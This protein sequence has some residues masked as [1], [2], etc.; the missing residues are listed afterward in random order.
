MFRSFHSAALV[1]GDVT[2]A[3]RLAFAP[4]EAR[5]SGDRGETRCAFGAWSSCLRARCL[6]LSTPRFGG[7]RELSASALS[8]VCPVARPVARLRLFGSIVNQ[9]LFHCF[10]VSAVCVTRV[11]ATSPFVV[12]LRPSR[13]GVLAF[14]GF[15]LGTVDS[16][17]CTS[18]GVN[19]L[20][21][22]S[23]DRRGAGDVRRLRSLGPGTRL[24]GLQRLRQ[25][26]VRGER[27][28]V[29][30]QNGIADLGHVFPGDVEEL[31]PPRLLRKRDA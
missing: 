4:R 17:C 24:R 11:R 14:F 25:L 16:H 1:F 29:E 2:P 21:S 5:A 31:M 23:R 9:P 22:C 6:V 7:T 15:F 18:Q 12:V 19:V 10:P 30:R 3:R 28:R 13:L 27:P 8:R 20:P 26:Q